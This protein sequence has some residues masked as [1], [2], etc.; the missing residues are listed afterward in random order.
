MTSRGYAT[1]LIESIGEDIALTSHIE[2]KLRT[3]EDEKEIGN[4][5]KM[6][7]KVLALRREKMECLLEQGGNPNP[8]YWCIAKHAI[9]SFW[10]QMEV[11]EN[12]QEDSDLE[13]LKKNGELLAMALS[14]F[15]GMEFKVCERCLHDLWLSK[16]I[17]KN[18]R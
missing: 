2:E 3:S 11:W 6:L 10:R 1:D 18:N 13:R 16:E 5:K 12:T 15:L 17:E 8:L 4:L 9:G 14:L 7:Q